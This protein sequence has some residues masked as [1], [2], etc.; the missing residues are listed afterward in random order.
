MKIICIGRNYADHAKE[1]NNEVPKVPVFFMKPENALVYDNKPV[2]YPDFTKDLQYETEIVVKISRL[3]KNI[4]ERFAS[5]YYEEIGIGID[6]TA[7]DLQRDCMKNGLPWEIAKSFDNSAPLGTFL[8]K[9][10]FANIQNIN[11]HLEINGE[12]RQSGCTKDM[13]FSIDTL[14][15]YVSQFNTLKTG[16]LIFTGT[17]VGVGPVQLDERLQAYIEG[18]CLLDFRVK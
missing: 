3:G 8:P 18:D 15:A 13:I 10:Q 12:R 7:R 16:D 9:S 11:F 5:R 2:F 17:P 1:L 14:I 6:F 4:E